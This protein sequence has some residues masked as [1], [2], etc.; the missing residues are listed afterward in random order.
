MPATLEAITQQESVYTNE[1]SLQLETILR[2]LLQQTPE[3]LET[4]EYYLGNKDGCPNSEA[5]QEQE[6]ELEKM[7]SQILKYGAD[8]AA[9]L[10][11]FQQTLQEATQA[12]IAKEAV[13]EV[14]TDPER[15]T[16][17]KLEEESTAT[18]PSLNDDMSESLLTTNTDQTTAPT[19][20]FFARLCGRCG[21]LKP[22]RISED[23]A[24]SEKP[25]DTLGSSI[26]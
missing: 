18:P 26:N 19:T 11:Q 22:R 15:K 14:S 3:N 6:E 9:K 8:W 17:A 1:E 25:G 4:Y 23:L 16:G 12:R 20:S 21:T 2:T 7:S 5:L 10:V 24:C 13:P